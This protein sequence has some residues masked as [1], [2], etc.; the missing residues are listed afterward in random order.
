M[1]LSLKLSQTAC[2]V[3][4]LKSIVL[5]FNMNKSTTM[6]RLAAT[7]I[8][9]SQKNKEPLLKFISITMNSNFKRP[10]K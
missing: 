8:S 4:S 2:A 10:S 9:H 3:V 1:Q 5:L 6:S 7:Y